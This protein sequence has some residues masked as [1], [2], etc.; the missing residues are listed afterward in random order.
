MKAARAVRGP[1]AFLTVQEGCDKF[2]AFCVVPYTRGGEVSRP[3]ARILDEAKAL[4]DGGA[5]EL[6]LLGQNVNAYHGADGRGGTRTLAGLLEDLAK[7]SGLARLR[8]TT[9]HPLDVTD[10]LIAAH[11]DIPQVMPYLHLP[12]Q[13]GS[14]KILAAMNRRHTAAQYLAIIEKLRAATPHLA[15]SGDFIVG[16]PG[17]SEADFQDTLRLVE[18]VGYAQAYSFKY[19]QRPGTP[20]ADWD[21]Q[22]SEAD[23]ADRLA[24]LQELLNRQQR[25]FNEAQVGQRL[26]VLLERAGKFPGQLVG[27]SPY[28]QAVHVS[29]PDLAI[30]DLV[31]VEIVSAGPNSLEGRQL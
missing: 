9:S 16:F 15:L 6:T 23:K 3:V 31:E 7:L 19:S 8:Y 17:E 27:R 2:C 22:V 4:I 14:D 29:A 20:A 18:T 12:V 1:A 10:D 21:A 30:G 28:L 26:G 25:A 5:K 11:R 13:A 24:R